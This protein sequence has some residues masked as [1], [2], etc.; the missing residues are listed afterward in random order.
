MFSGSFSASG[1][2]NSNI[3]SSKTFSRKQNPDSE[4]KLTVKE[5]E[6]SPNII[7]NND[8]QG[9]SE[10]SEYEIKRKVVKNVTVIQ[11]GD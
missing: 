2:G 6:S 4:F 7:N 9:E 5:T 8:D 3:K 1:S 11:G 10:G